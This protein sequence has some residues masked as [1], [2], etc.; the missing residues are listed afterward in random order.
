M[1]VDLSVESSPVRYWLMKVRWV[2]P[3]P[4]RRR[5]LLG[6]RLFLRLMNYESVMDG[7][8]LNDVRELLDMTLDVQGDVVE[9]GCARCGT[10]V[11]MANHLRSRNATKTIYACDTFDGFAPEE[12]KRETQLGRA[13]ASQSA[14]AA[15]GQYE[16]VKEKLFRL[17]IEG[18]IVPVKGLFQDTFSRWVMIWDKLSFVL[19]DC[20]LEES[21]LFCA[22]ALWPLLA[23][24]GIMAFDDYTSEQFKG[25]RIAVDKFV[26]ETPVRHIS[27]GLMRRLYFLQKQT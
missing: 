11:I 19:V 1:T 12:L 7:A 23:S 3:R 5:A 10:S 13:D 15:P 14:F 26:A 2:V 21:M 22:R 18:R 4:L 20:D 27:H 25:A 6:S 8:G 17:G 16:Y 9:C 24:G